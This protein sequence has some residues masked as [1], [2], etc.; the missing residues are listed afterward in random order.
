MA[1]LRF[2]AWFSPS[3]RCPLQGATHTAPAR[4]ARERQPLSGNWISSL[5]RTFMNISL[6]DLPTEFTSERLLLRR[7]RPDDITMYYQMLRNNADH[8]YEFLPSFLLNVRSE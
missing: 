8:L 1:V 2:S 3:R 6:L 7:Y 4:S 5:E